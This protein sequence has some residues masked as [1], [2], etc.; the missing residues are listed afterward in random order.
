[1]TNKNSHERICVVLNPRAGNGKAGAKLNEI[2]AHLNRY[3]KHWEIHQ[4]KAPRHATHLAQKACNAGVDI[5]AAVGGDG[6]CHEV[7]NGI[8]TAERKAIFTLIPF[9]TGG[10]LRRTLQ[11]PKNTRRAIQIAAN[12]TDLTVDVGKAMITTDNGQELRY[13]INVAGFGANGAVAEKTNRE[14]K[15]LGGRIT[16]LKATLHTTMTY[17]APKVQLFWNGAKESEWSGE[18]LSCF[19]ANAQFCGGGM[20]VAP[21]RAITDQQLYLSILP[22][23]S[24]PKQLFHI[25]KLYDGTIHK[26]PKSICCSI[27]ELKAAAPHGVEV[28]ID[29]DGEIGGRL[30]ASFSIEKQALSVRAQWQP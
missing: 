27:T 29:L 8:M 9:G 12:G 17:K 15:V 5:V 25:P 24:V 13:F 21:S 3:F 28:L 19:V 22:N 2:K 16:F 1:M 4:T 18:L 7:V 20:K 30:P 6:S 23:M 11:T 10:D 14:S 26:V